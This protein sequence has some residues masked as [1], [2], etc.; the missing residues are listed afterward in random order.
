MTQWDFPQRFGFPVF[1]VLATFAVLAGA[2]VVELLATFAVVF[3][4]LVGAV[5]PPQAIA[6]KLIEPINNIFFIFSSDCRNTHAVSYVRPYFEQA[7]AFYLIVTVMVYG[8]FS[9]FE[10][11]IN[12]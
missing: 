5:F 11:T 3:A 12:V 4:V 9:R 7:S 8:V 6:N 10:S 1:V 2:F